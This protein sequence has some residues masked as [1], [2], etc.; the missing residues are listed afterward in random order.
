VPRL[1]RV[2]ASDSGDTLAPSS[3]ETSAYSSRSWPDAAS[4]KRRPTDAALVDALDRT[5]FGVIIAA[6]FS[7][8]AFA[9]LYAQRL[10]D[11]GD[12]L[13]ATDG[14]LEAIRAADT[15]LLRDLIARGASR[16][17]TTAVTL[18]LPRNFSVRPLIVYLPGHGG[19][20]KAS[21]CATL[22]VCDPHHEP[23]ADPSILSR[24]FGF[25]RAEATLALH[26]M[27]GATVEEAATA[28][29]VSHHTVRTHLKRMLLKTDTCRQAELLRLLLTC[30]AQVRL[31]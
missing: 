1:L 3:R 24:L 31:D 6:P 11:S 18:Q 29:F 8:P 5:Q 9:N 25:T 16:Q 17:V 27:R 22:F 23:L 2:P 28:L 26:L 7:R 15:R 21:D 12:G 10:L 19:A 13:L 20:A 4:E 30:S 14:G